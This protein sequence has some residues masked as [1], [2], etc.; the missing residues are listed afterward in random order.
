MKVLL[1]AGVFLMVLDSLMCSGMWSEPRDVLA[2][3]VHAGSML[4]DAMLT[5]GA[6]LQAGVIRVGVSS[7]RTPRST[8]PSQ[9]A[10]CLPL[11]SSV[12]SDYQR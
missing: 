5:S 8:S 6:V 9:S 2:V 11:L 3:Q 7:L 12:S 10:I 4:A 1:G